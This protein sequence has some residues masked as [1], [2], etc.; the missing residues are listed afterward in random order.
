MPLTDEFK[1][2]TG[3]IREEEITTDADE[4]RHYNDDAALKILQQDIE[5]G[6]ADDNLKA[7]TQQW[8]KSDILLQ[9]PVTSLGD[10]TKARIPFYTL[11]DTVD[12][13]A[14]KITGAVFYDN[15][16]FMLRPNPRLNQKVMWAK[17]AVAEVQLREMD[18]ETE[19]DLGVRQCALLGTMVFKYGWMSYKKTVPV[20]KSKAAPAKIETPIGT[21]QF[22]TDESD[23]FEKSTEQVRVDTPWL[24]WRDLAFVLVDPSTQVGDIRRAKWVC[25]RDYLTFDDI[26]GLRDCP[27]YDIPERGQLETFFF[28]PNL[29]T[30]DSGNL[31]EIQPP[32]ARA[33]I[34]H[35]DGRNIDTSADPFLRKL[36]VIERWTGTQV[37][38]AL[39]WKGRYLLIRNEP[40]PLG[41]IPYLSSTWR[42][43]P[44][45]FYGQG[46]G[47]LI[48]D[49][50][51]ME[52]GIANAWLD[53]LAFTAQPA[54]VKSRGMNIPSQNQRIGLGTIVEVEGDV[55]AGYG[56]LE[57]PKVD[58]SL[59]QGLN[60]AR[61]TAASTS[62][63]NELVGQGNSLGA[64]AVTGMRSGTGANLVGQAAA[65][66]Q[67]SVIER[68]LR[69]V[70]I[71][72]LYKMDELN[73][74]FLPP[75]ALRKILSEDMAHDYEDFSH[76]DFRNTKVDYDILAGAHLGARK[77]M[78]AF[79][80]FLQQIVNTPSLLELASAQGKKFDFNAF[81]GFMGDLS[82][83]SPNQPFFVDM[84]PE[85]KQRA[86]QSSP[87]ALQAQ[88]LQAQAGMQQDK[89][90]AA[91]E[92][93]NTRSLGRAANE[94]IRV[95]FERQM[96]PM[97][98]GL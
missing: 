32:N 98:S 76:I 18:I 7:N 39:R 8:L 70:F 90:Q 5:T 13:L 68:F 46:L 83:F 11:S 94:V 23:E 74:E 20:Y 80:P 16:P 43:L 67:D 54:Y 29:E 33:W 93:E 69:Q 57:Q 78:A 92:L 71:P 21:Q 96:E 84:T 86:A 24:K 34:T 66:R 48:G 87:A 82:G 95:G 6:D 59:M 81:I 4:I 72:W 47:Q 19:I 63:A 85:E 38:V 64:G 51:R 88:K 36:E 12:S 41:C 53:I 42:P 9:S 75:N 50:Q 2:P 10:S 26:D 1:K 52:Q 3:P 79:M 60:L 97:V 65:G 15:P 62:G 17:E 30:P 40:N 89:Q 55:R 35:A 58:P 31:A 27:G 22:D 14:T 91:N 25:D 45:S 37:T 28:P 44:R 61:T 77:Q 56:L 49:Y 73:S